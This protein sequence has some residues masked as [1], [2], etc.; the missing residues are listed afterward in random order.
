MKIIIIIL[1]IVYCS[2]LDAQ[3]QKKGTFTDVRDGRVYK[4][5]TIGTQTWMAENLAFKASSGCWAYNNDTSKVAIYGYLYDWETAKKVSPS[6]WHLPSDEEWK[7]LITYLGGEDRA[8]GKLK[9]SSVCGKPNTGATDSSGFS[10]Q[11][12]GFR[13]DNDSFFYVGYIG[14]WW[15]TNEYDTYAY[16]RYMSSVNNNIFSTF[17]WKEYGL[18]V[19]CVKD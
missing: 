5:V 3:A 9:S 11:L 19:R 7:T 8:G 15:T 4:T 17:C 12:G 10:V 13:Y 14:Y 6:S 16:Y 2:L 18:S 1:I